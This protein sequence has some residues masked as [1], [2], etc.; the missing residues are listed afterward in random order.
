MQAIPQLKPNLSSGPDSFPPLLVKKLSASLAEPLSL[1]FT[2]FMSVGKIPRAWRRA[3]VTPICNGGCAC[4][5]SDYRPI[6][7]TNVLYKIMER[8][9]SS[10]FTWLSN[11][12]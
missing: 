7:L 2:S 1:I 4:D 3:T 12:P 9:Y 11:A 6:S 5:V 8:V 10:R